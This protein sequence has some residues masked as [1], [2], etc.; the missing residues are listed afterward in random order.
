M[1]NSIYSKH[2]LEELT[3]KP[4]AVWPGAFLLGNLMHDELDGPERDAFAGCFGSSGYQVHQII[5]DDLE[6]LT[7]ESAGAC[8]ERNQDAK[9]VRSAMQ[10]LT[11][12]QAD[13]VE[14]RYGI[15]NGRDYTQAEVAE[16]LGITHQMVN[17]HEQA[18]LA[19]MRKILTKVF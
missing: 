7:T 11:D 14:L 13:V 4:P 15:K 12:K 16:M 18:A 10:H 19:K 6:K 17:K 3:A 2:R 8:A 1:S 9:Y 5:P